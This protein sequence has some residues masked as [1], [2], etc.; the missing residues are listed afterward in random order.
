MFCRKSVLFAL[1]LFFPA[2]SGGADCDPAAPPA[3]RKETA[4]R[5]IGPAAMVPNPQYTVKSVLE[6]DM[7][8]HDF[9][10]RNIGDALLQIEKVESG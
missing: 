9:V 3:V 5:L 4:V 1:L 2:M 10:I 8:S 6:G 7:V